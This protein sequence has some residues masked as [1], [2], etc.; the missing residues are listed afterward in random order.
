MQKRASWLVAAIS[1]MQ[2]IMKTAQPMMMVQRRPMKSATSPAIRAPKK[3]PADRMDTINDFSQE[4]KA[5][6]VESM[7][8]VVGLPVA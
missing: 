7:P 8:G 3:V 2:P 5:K 1:K 6:V 4:G